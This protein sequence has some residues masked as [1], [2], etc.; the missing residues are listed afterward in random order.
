LR[1]KRAGWEI[2]HLPSMT[3]L[4]HAGKSGIDP[5][6][7]AQ[8]LFSRLQYAQK[9]FSPAH[10]VVYRGVIGLRYLVRLVPVGANGRAR[11]AASL[12]ALRVLLGVDEP[13][14]G[15]PPR[16]AVALL[17]PTA[18]G[19]RLRRVSSSSG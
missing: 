1:I 6:T 7:T 14:F 18:G 4:H 15:A 8:E 19:A 11:A 12:R 13:P 9:N 5:R 17:A 2:R 10:R 3:I 16:Q